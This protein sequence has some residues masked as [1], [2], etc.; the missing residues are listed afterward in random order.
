VVT[1]WSA[2]ETFVNYKHDAV[3]SPNNIIKAPEAYFCEKQVFLTKSLISIQFVADSKYQ[4]DVDRMLRV[5]L[6]I[7]SV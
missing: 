1:E 5:I 2:K 3:L 7:Y 4:L 6:E